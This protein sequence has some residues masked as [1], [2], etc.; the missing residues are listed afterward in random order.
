M[1]IIQAIEKVSGVDFASA[2]DKQVSFKVI[3]D[4]IR[5]VSFA[6]SDGALPSN[7][8]RGYILRR[9][10]R[11]SVMHGRKLGISRSFDRDRKS[12]V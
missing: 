9:L 4:H 6:I 1:P 7:E 2:G 12:V 8:G 3:A 10:I 11:R 5:A